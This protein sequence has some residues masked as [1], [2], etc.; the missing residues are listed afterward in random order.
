[1]DGALPARGD[2]EP[3]P[4]SDAAPE[5]ALQGGEGGGAGAGAGASGT[6]DDASFTPAFTAAQKSF[7]DR[8]NDLMGKAQSLLI[9]AI[10]VLHEESRA[11]EVTTP[12]GLKQK[13]QGLID[14]CAFVAC[15]V[16]ALLRH[17]EKEWDLPLSPRIVFGYM[18]YDVPG[19][20]VSVP[21]LWVET[22]HDEIAEVCMQV[23]GRKDLADRERVRITDIAGGITHKRMKLV[24]GRP[25]HAT[26]QN[27]QDTEGRVA[28]ESAAAEDVVEA[29]YTP[30][31]EA[32]VAPD[33]AAHVEQ[34]RQVARAPL[35]ALRASGG[36]RTVRKFKY[37][38]QKLMTQAAEKEVG[39]YKFN[40]ASL[41][42]EEVMPNGSA[43]PGDRP[44]AAEVESKQ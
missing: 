29:S 24:L 43:V 32:A 28:D 36:M 2:S 4:S 19:L 38:L 7:I 20:R 9:V 42:V 30:T 10:M 27:V 25:F 14:S 17:V 12:S 40:M 8:M 15:V 44:Q 13:T 18:N 16:L 39:K 35:Q 37:I 3:Q 22:R 11:V 34:L 31:P 21:H 41:G 26:L 6:V 23:T 33:A 1:M 5:R